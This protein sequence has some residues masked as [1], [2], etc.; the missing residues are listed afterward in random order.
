[1]RWFDL[2]EAEAVM[3]FPTER[4]RRSRPGLDGDTRAAHGDDARQPAPA[5]P[6]GSPPAHGPA[7]RHEDCARFTDSAGWRCPPYG[8][9][10]TS[11][12]PQLRAGPSTRTWASCGRASRRAVDWRCAR[13]DPGS[14]GPR[15]YSRCTGRRNMTLIVYRT[16]ERVP[17]AQR[18]QPEVGRRAGCSVDGHEANCAT[19]SWHSLLPRPAPPILAGLTL[20][21]RAPHLRGRRGSPAV[22]RTGYTGETA[23]RFVAW[24]DGPTWDA[25]WRGSGRGSALRPGAVTRCA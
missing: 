20:T 16:V 13:L 9:S 22:A 4:H 15:Q 25:S 21:R 3:S 11:T 24:A 6:R 19:R 2:G 23:S 18:L 14:P 7:W 1:V 12:T 10:S 5:R 17:V 8:P